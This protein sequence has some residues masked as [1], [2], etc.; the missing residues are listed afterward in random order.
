MLQ[1]NS[2]DRL[3]MN[4]FLSPARQLHEGSK[5]SLAGV[6]AQGSRHSGR[7][8]TQGFCHWDLG[9]QPLEFFV[10]FKKAVTILP[11]VCW[12]RFCVCFM[13]RPPSWSSESLS[14]ALC[15]CLCWGGNRLQVFWRRRCDIPKIPWPVWLTWSLFITWLSTFI[16]V[17]SGKG[18]GLFLPLGTLHCIREILIIMDVFWILNDF[19]S[20]LQSSL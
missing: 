3:L 14:P 16:P 11:N 19:S 18:R 4:C 5:S 2:V 10:F 6:G 1:S 7:L 9:I 20:V 8:S 13:C 17:F 12:S 15:S